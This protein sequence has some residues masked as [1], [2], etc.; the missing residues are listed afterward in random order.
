VAE[1][2]IPPFALP[3]A[4]T[5]HSFLNTQFT[6]LSKMSDEVDADDDDLDHDL[7]YLYRRYNG[8]TVLLNYG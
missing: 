4:D 3:S 7:S 8:T 5:R 1:V 2:I 6:A